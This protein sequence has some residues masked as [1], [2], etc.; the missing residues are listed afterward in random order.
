M[1]VINEVDE[2]GDTVYRL[3]WI[4]ESNRFQQ[5]STIVYI[6]DNCPFQNLHGVHVS[7]SCSLN[8]VNQQLRL[9][10]Q[11]AS[12]SIVT[13]WLKTEI[14]LFYIEWNY[15]YFCFLIFFNTLWRYRSKIIVRIWMDNLYR[16][17][18]EKVGDRI[19]TNSI[20]DVSGLE[21]VSFVFSRKFLVY[22]F[23]FLV[24]Y[25]YG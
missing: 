2:G 20:R 24:L 25:M 12:L 11:A 17:L 14:Y 23:F 9:G 7:S 21:W 22:L 10:C 18:V 5:L 3:S 6:V 4:H 19:E 8:R 1:D 13:H 16:S 15:Y